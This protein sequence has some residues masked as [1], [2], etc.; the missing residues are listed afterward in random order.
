MAW[1]DQEENE[2][3]RIAARLALDANNVR[4]AIGDRISVIVQNTALMLVACTAASLLR[5]CALARALFSLHFLWLL[6]TMFYSYCKQQTGHSIVAFAT[7]LKELCRR[8]RTQWLW[9]G[10][11]QYEDCCCLHSEAKIVGL[12]S[13]NLETPL[14]RCFWKGQIA[15]SGFGI[16]QFSLYASY[17]L[18]LWYASWLVKHEISNFSNTIRVFMVLMVSANG[19]AETLTLAPDF[20]KGGRAMRSVF[21]LLDRKLKLNLMIHPACLN[22]FPRPQSSCTSGKILA[23]VGPSGCGKSSVIALI[24]RF[25]DPSSGPGNTISSLRKHIAIVPQEPCLFG[26]TIYENIAYGMSQQQSLK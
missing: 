13:T 1:F 6:Q 20:I 26:T 21:D 8:K 23:L 19:A 15:G 24:Q 7:I 10:H 12:F 25:Y 4:S 17:A 11:S 2:S 5:R 3:A 14:R 16:A 18:G 9:R 22:H